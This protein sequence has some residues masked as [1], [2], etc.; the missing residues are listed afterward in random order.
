MKKPRNAIMLKEGDQRIEARMGEVKFY[1]Y[2]CG[3]PPTTRGIIAKHVNRGMQDAVMEINRILAEGEA[4][5]ACGAD[6]VP[7]CRG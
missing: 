3:C 7:R 2:I 1:V 4:S 6:K 5:P